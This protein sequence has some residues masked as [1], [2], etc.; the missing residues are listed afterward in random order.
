M[1]TL[2]ELSALAHELVSAE[3]E[4]EHAEKELKDSKE[5]ARFL[6]EESLPAAMQELGLESVTINTGEKVSIKQDVYLAIPVERRE[7]AY[8]WLESNG[9]G[10]L[11]KMEVSVGFGKGELTK[12][13][14][15]VDDLRDKGL[16]AECSRSVHAQTLKAWA[17]EQLRAGKNIPL[18]MFGARPVWV[19]KVK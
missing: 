11:I 1:I 8:G 4:V 13:N 7:D 15:L 9:F 18:D 14:E 16:A 5:R 19:A 6:R 17:N 2:D 12:A 3:R 10:G